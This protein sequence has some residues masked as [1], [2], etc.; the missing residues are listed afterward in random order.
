MNELIHALS[1]GALVVA[2]TAGIDVPSQAD[3]S[4]SSEDVASAGGGN[5]SPGFRIGRHFRQHEPRPDPC[6]RGRRVDASDR[7]CFEALIAEPEVAEVLNDRALLPGIADGRISTD[8]MIQQL[9]ISDAVPRTR[10]PGREAE[11]EEDE[12]LD[13][14]VIEELRSAEGFEI[15]SVRFTPRGPILVESYVPGENG[16]PF[17]P[18]PDN[19]N[20]LDIPEFTLD[21]HNTLAPNVNGY[22]MRIRMNGQTI[23]TMQW[24]WARNPN[25]A[26]APAAGWNMNRRMHIVS[27]SKFMTTIGLVHLLKAKGIDTDDKIISYLPNYWTPGPN[28]GLINFEDL[29]NHLSGLDTNGSSSSSWATMQSIV[30]GGVTASDV[31]STSNYENM[32]FGILRI[33]IATIGGFI[34]P[35][36]NFG[37]ES[38]NDILWNAI[39]ASAYNS[40]M[41]ANVFNPVGA[42][43][44]LTKSP[45]TAL[46]HRYDASGTGWNTSS[47]VTTPGGVGWHM[48]IN[49]VLD[50]AR[51]LR[52]GQIVGGLDALT[53][54]NQ[55]WGLNS[56]LSGFDTDAGRLYYKPGR[57]TDNSNPAV[58]RTEQCLL[59][60]MPDNMEI[61]V[62]VNSE[63]GAGGQSLTNVVRTLYLN[64]IVIVP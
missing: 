38:N 45:S 31:G 44:V 28:V 39:T 15:S 62:F 17:V 46:A 30:Q 53:I 16:F 21:L 49:E 3:G 37:S 7:R 6:A 1:I 5:S 40:Y 29:M 64:N 12:V 36:A 14:R 20:Y 2:F 33:L 42:F 59:M 10:L 23:I 27:L 56:P 58:A 60:M 18:I 4:F 32:N 51:A 48:T 54:L 24:N 63:I 47:F 8:E 41:Q 26:D 34:H 11:P 13:P 43:P 19:K 57:W 61:V 22:A 9:R 25:P 55:S 52:I 35:A 50:V